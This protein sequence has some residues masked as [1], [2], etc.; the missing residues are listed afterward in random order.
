MICNYTTIVQVTSV[1]RHQLYDY[2]LNHIEL[3]TQ[4][5]KNYII[6]G[7]FIISHGMHQSSQHNDYLEHAKSDK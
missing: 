5:L 1:E 6:D 4:N 2:K 3:T 7:K